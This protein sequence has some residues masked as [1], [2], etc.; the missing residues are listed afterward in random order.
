M[1]SPSSSSSLCTSLAATSVSLG[2]RGS[3]TRVVGG[4]TSL[5]PPSRACGHGTTATGCTSPHAQT[6]APRQ[7]AADRQKN[8]QVEGQ[9]F[10]QMTQQTQMGSVLGVTPQEGKVRHGHWNQV[11]GHPVA[12]AA[13]PQDDLPRWDILPKDPWISDSL[14]TPQGFPPVSV[15]SCLLSPLCHI[16]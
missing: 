7:A 1:P 4:A 6:E 15:S 2:L 3:H 9:V 14:P 5:L 11:K 13:L 10:P 12:R 16:Y 8:R